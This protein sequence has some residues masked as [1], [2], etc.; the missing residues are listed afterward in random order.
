MSRTGLISV[1]A[2]PEGAAATAGESATTAGEVAAAGELVGR[3]AGVARGRGDDHLVAG[4]Q[5]GLDLDESAA[6]DAD[7]D[8]PLLVLPVDL[9]GH[10]ALAAG[11]AQRRARDPQHVLR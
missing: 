5:P 7:L 2:P 4:V 9:H 3:G 8:L 1:A 10:R 11:R 6:G